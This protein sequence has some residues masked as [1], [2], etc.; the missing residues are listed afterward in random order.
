[1]LVWFG[2]LPPLA[3]LMAPFPCGQGTRT[4]AMNCALPPVMLP[5]PLPVPILPF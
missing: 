4:P 1:M 2:Q 3:R 5:W